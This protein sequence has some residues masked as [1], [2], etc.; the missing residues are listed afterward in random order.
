MSRK[1][2]DELVREALPDLRRL[3][4]RSIREQVGGARFAG[5]TSLLGDA[6]GR[7]AGQ[8]NLPENRDQLQGL[9]MLALRRALADRMRRGL[10][11]KR[12]DARLGALAYARGSHGSSPARSGDDV[13][14]LRTRIL[15]AMHALAEADP[16]AAEALFL[17]VQAGMGAAAVA[18]EL[19]VSVPTVER[20]LR[21][22]RAFL[23]AWL[24]SGDG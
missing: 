18:T 20:D 1:P 23:A 10:A 12:D 24:S 19:G 21:A 14:E 11:A 22:A 16:R 4:R 13:S 9:A 7:L 6:M 17:T 5:P 3:A 2:F 8:R 15:E